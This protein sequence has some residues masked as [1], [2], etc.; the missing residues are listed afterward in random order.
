MLICLTPKSKKL[1]KLLKVNQNFDNNL[2]FES[3]QFFLL[4]NAMLD[5]IYFYRINNVG[6]TDTIVNIAVI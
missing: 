5:V 3:Q 4:A 1:S 6:I 2:L